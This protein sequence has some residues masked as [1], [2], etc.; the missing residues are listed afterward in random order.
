[1]A[2]R[3]G[4]PLQDMEFVQFHPTGIYGAGCL[5]TEGVR[6][7]G[8][9]PAQL[10]RRA[11]HGA[12]RAEREGPRLARR[13]QPRDDHRDPRRPRRRRAQGPH[14]PQPDA[15]RRRRASREAAGHRRDRAHL[16]RRR[17]DQ[18]A[19]PGVPTVHYNMGGIPTNYHGEVVRKDGDDPDAVVPGLYRDRR[20]GLRVGARRQPPRL[21]LAARPGRVRPRG[22]AALRRD[23][24]AGPAAQG[25]AGDRP[26]TRRWRNFDRL[27]NANGSHADRG[28]PPRT[29]SARC[30][31]TPRCSAP[32]KTLQEGCA[33]I[34][35]VFA[36]FDD[37]QRLRPLA[38]LELR[39]D[40]DA[41]AAEPARTGG[42]DDQLGRAA[43]REPRRA[44]ARGF[45]GARRRRTG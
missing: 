37:V 39:P 18:G 6:G 17:R 25:P 32:A 29:C 45:P 2:L 16:R 12:L 21:Q 41:R 43:P 7:E 11:L 14:P 28:D 9:Y 24:Q 5:I 40:R 3:A 36:S 4:L 33:K 42:R 15:P 44:R 34:A 35:E 10:Q 19:D 8:G 26:A 23:D 38:D 13:R 22:R 1:M 30:R 27:R 20:G 31:P